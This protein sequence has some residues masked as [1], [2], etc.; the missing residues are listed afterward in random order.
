MATIAIFPYPWAADLNSSFGLA[1]KL[2]LRGHRAVFVCMPDAESRIRAQGFEFASFLAPVFPPGTIEGLADAQARDKGGA[3]DSWLDRFRATCSLLIEGELERLVSS[4]GADVLLISSWTP[5]IGIAASRLGI[6]VLNFSSTFLSVEDRLVPPFG[7]DIVPGRSPLWRLRTRLAWS[8]MFLGRRLFRTAV[9]VRPEMERLARAFR[10][11]LERIDFRVET[12]PR[13]RQPELVLCPREFDLP[14][15]R[16][17]EG[18]VAVEAS[19]DTERRDVEFPWERLRE[20]RPLVYCSL[21]S[22]VTFKF[23]DE[24]TR[25]VQL[26]L[27]L[28]TVRPGL[29]GVVPIGRHVDPAG[30]RCPENVVLVP[31]APQLRLLARARLMI[32]HGGLTGVKEAIYHGVPMIVIPFFYDQPGNAARVVFH[33]LGRKAPLRRLDAERLG[34][35]VDGVLSGPSYGAAARSMSRVFADYERAA[36]AVERIEEAMRGATRR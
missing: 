34:E 16:D 14:R 5:W 24:V 9:N 26:L 8:R 10:L 36:P 1:R 11:P 18:A 32:T 12:W 27:D 25:L 7:T 35:L 3:P 29:Q 22:V 19:I 15:A 6:P 2:V 17:P 33:G 28:M 30:F 13:L 4:L 21:G 20:D 23:R 31:E